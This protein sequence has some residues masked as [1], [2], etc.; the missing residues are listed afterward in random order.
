[1]KLPLPTRHRIAG[2]TLMYR[3]GKGRWEKVADIATIREG[4]DL[5]QTHPDRVRA[6]HWWFKFTYAKET[7]VKTETKDMRV[8]PTDPAAQTEGLS[9]R[10]YAA[11]HIM[12]GFAADSRNVASK[13]YVTAT[14]AVAVEWADALAE[15]LKPGSGQ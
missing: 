11:L 8:F 12:A 2:M 9:F 15:A 4:L 13:E 7:D 3:P 6:A 1:M 14:A 5:M 10:E